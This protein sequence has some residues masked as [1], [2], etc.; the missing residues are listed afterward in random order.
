MIRLTLPLPPSVNSYH[1]SVPLRNGVPKVLISRAG[2][3]W[4]KKALQIAQMQK[5]QTLEGEVA[6]TLT[7]YFR[8]RRRDLDN[9]VKPCLDL[10]QA[11]GVV[12]NDRQVWRIA[13][14]RKIDK[15][16]PRVEIEVT[17]LAT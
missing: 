1:R 5:P 15:G 2:R 3:A 4:K 14:E 11:I 7:V 13:M 9:T 12:A 10:L 6:V 16:D 17:A 8:D